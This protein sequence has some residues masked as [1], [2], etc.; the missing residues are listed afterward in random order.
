MF[1]KKVAPL[2][3]L[4]SLPKTSIKIKTPT[5]TFNTDTGLPGTTFIQTT[6]LAYVGELSASELTIQQVAGTLENAM[7][8]KARKV[9]M[10]QATDPDDIIEVGGTDYR[11]SSMEQ[12]DG[13]YVLVVVPA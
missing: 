6:A 2:Y 8:L 9:I 7:L 4:R 1:D 3:F 11:I 5:S 10:S 12:R 13:L